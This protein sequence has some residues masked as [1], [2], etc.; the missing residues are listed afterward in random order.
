MI[1]IPPSCN[2]PL[3]LSPLQLAAQHMKEISLG[4][5][6][7]DLVVGAPAAHAVAIAQIESGLAVQAEISDFFVTAHNYFNHCGIGNNQW[8][9]GE[10]VRRDR[11]NYECVHGGH[12]HRTARRKRV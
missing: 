11:R 9:M 12:H 7:A 8:P 10:R 3:S 4:T 6:E 2:S 1:F 5:E